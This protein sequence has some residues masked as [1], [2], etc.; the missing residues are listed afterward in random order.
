MI[1]QYLRL[2]RLEYASLDDVIQ[3][4]PLEPCGCKLWRFSVDWHG[5]PTAFIAGE[6][7]RVTRYVLTEKLNRSILPGMEALHSCDNPS[8]VAQ[9]HLR[10]GT[11]KQNMQDMVDR[12]RQS[13]GE[14]HPSSKLTEEKVIAIR[15]ISKLG[16][17]HEHIG[18]VFGI[19]GKTVYSVVH[20]KTW[21]HIP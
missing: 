9:A 4:I 6:I 17:T 15:S 8:C 1:K 20:R 19:T 18:C 14:S 10:E 2:M 13:R 12:Q 21:R 3:D 11:H 16:Y 5:Y 7:I